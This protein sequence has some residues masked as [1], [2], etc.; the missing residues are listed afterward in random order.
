MARK[1]PKPLPPK[2]KFFPK[3]WR[4]CKDFVDDIVHRRYAAPEGDTI[5]CVMPDGFYYYLYELWQDGRSVERRRLRDLNPKLNSTGIEIREPFK[6]EV[7]PSD[8]SDD[9]PDI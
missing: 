5:R 6:D 9:E 8:E 7:A 2:G 3:N 4:F 1:Q